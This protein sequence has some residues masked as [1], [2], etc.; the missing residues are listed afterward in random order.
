MNELLLL[1]SGVLLAWLADWLFGFWRRNQDEARQREAKLILNRHGLSPQLYLASI[2]EKDQELRSA[3][4]TFA[5]TGHVILDSKGQVVG[6]LLPM[7]KK[8]PHL[9]L[10]VS[11][12]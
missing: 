5:F 10:V 12:D 2:G 7:V 3:L 11:N 1:F 9:R 4:D 8:G 6:K